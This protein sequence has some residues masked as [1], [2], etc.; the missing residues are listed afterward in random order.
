MHS[1]CEMY[2]NPNRV[3][4]WIGVARG[5]GFPDDVNKGEQ[6][7]KATACDNVRKPGLPKKIA[8]NGSENIV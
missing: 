7:R 5:Q 1:P 3:C 4:Y 2:G 8:T 6:L